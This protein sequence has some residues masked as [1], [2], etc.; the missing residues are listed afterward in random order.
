MSWFIATAR[1]KINPGGILQG[2]L[3]VILRYCI[4]GVLLRAGI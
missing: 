1:K 3:I 4:G 2:M